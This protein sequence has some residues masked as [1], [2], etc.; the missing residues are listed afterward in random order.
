M[1]IR[2]DK[3]VP[4]FLLVHNGGLEFG[5]DFIIKYLDINV[6]PMVGEAAHDGVVDSQSCLP[7]LLT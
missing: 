4:N 1:Y 7:D 5:A 3:L 2:R 6:V